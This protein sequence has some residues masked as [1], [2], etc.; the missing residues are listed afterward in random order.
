MNRPPILAVEG[1]RKRYRIR[2][3]GML[4]RTEAELWAVDDVSFAIAEGETVG[5]VG[6]SGCGKTTTAKMA[7]RLE[8]PS[9]GRILFRGNDLAGLGKA[10]LRTYRASVQAVF[11]DPW[12]SLNPRMRVGEIIG[13]PLLVNAG[14][15]RVERAERVA[16]LLEQVGLKPWQARLYPHEFSGGQ[17][18][19]ITIARA[20]SLSPGLIV[21][22][23]PVSALDVSVQAQ[24]M[25]LLRDLQDQLGLAFLLIAHSLGTVRY[26]CHRV[27]VMYLGQVVETADARALFETPRHPYTQ[28]LIAAAL[29]GRPGDADEEFP[30]IEGEVPSPTAPPPGCRFHTRCPQAMPVC[31]TTAPATITVAPGHET[32]C[33]L[34]G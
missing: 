8:Q 17:R 13:E 14:L 23:E 33:H 26:L 25:N 18:Q 11:Q 28:A 10:A 20:I 29:P 22:D 4:S 5:I 31:R 34:Y 7:L 21:L 27:V 9:E 24:I 3:G 2:T 1:V 32:R 19:R 30:A 12:S 6:E 16:R 15:S